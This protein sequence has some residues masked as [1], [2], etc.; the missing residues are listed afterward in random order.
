MSALRADIY[1]VLDSVLET[2]K[3]VAIMH[4]GHKLQIVAVLGDQDTPKTERLIK[5]NCTT[6]DPADLAELNWSN[7]WQQTT[8]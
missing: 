2:A 8:P 4:K 5:R 3:P 1:N 7:E 6:G